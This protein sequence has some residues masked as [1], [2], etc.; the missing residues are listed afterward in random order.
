MEKKLAPLVSIGVPVFNGN[1]LITETIESL[2]NQDYTNIEIIIS[3][4]AST[5]GTDEVCRQAANR[6]E[7]IKFYRQKENIGWQKNYE[8]VLSKSSGRYF[9]WVAAD[10]LRSTN[11]VSTLVRVME[12]DNR[13]VC[14]MSDVVDIDEH[15]VPIRCDPMEANRYSTFLSGVSHRYIFFL[16]PGFNTYHCVYGLFRSSALD[17]VSLNYR[18]MLYKSAGWEVPFLAQV[19]LLGAIV[20][21]PKRLVKYRILPNGMYLSEKENACLKERIRNYVGISSAL[22][23]IAFSSDM[24]ICRKLGIASK[25]L[26]Q[27]GIKLAVLARIAVI[28]LLK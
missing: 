4:N 1:P 10:D 6:Y 14:A 21:L 25:L 9:C 8:F 19:S 17:D 7:N 15:G 23:S 24:K 27:L 16:N 13:I 26:L 3:D 11:F 5:D 28:S 18:D 12:G 2:A 22:L 20:S